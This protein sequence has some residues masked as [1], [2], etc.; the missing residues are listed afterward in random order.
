MWAKD[1]DNEHYLIVVLD[2][3]SRCRL[4]WRLQPSMDADAFAEVV[5]LACEEACLDGV[6]LG[7]GLRVL[8]DRGPAL[9]SRSFGQYLGA[10]GL[11]PLGQG[12]SQ[13]GGVGVAGQ[14]RRRNAGIRCLLQREVV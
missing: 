12:A 4:A 5:E 10:K 6:P 9:I 13:P 2:N 7:N 8:S 11:P 3:S 14:G 1:A